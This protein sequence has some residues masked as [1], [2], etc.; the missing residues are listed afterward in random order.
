[1]TP[2]QA[3]LLSILS[4]P[5]EAPPPSLPRTMVVTAHPDD[6][7]V[8]AGSRLPRLREAR[9]V[10]I[11]D[12]APRNGEDASG[13]ELTPAE[14]ARARR[15]ELQTVLVKSGIAL[16]RLEWLDCPDQQASLQLVPLAQRL[17]ERM[18]LEKTEVVLTQPYAGGHP[19]HDATAFAVHAAVALLARRGAAV[20]AIVEMASCGFPSS[21]GDDGRVTVRLTPE[22]KQFKAELIASFTTQAETLGA[23]PL[24]AEAFRPSPRYDFRAPP[25]PGRLR[26]EHHPW[27]MD[28]ERFRALAS[29]AM[30]QLGL[31]GPL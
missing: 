17:A 13:Q 3:A 1:M 5:P 29:E 25:R 11:T 22:E 26:Y 12:G 14:Y 27:G 15:L 6:E 9:F 24:D 16:Q 28:G 2:A 23:F 18:A 31:E 20:P 4:A 8:G 30:Q 7:T 19:D 10:C 21:G